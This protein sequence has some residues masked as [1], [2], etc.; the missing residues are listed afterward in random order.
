MTSRK[1]VDVVLALLAHFAVGI[2][3]VAVAASVM[4]SLDVLRRML[5]NSEFA[6]DTDPAAPALGDPD[7]ARRGVDQPP[8]LPVVDASRGQREARVGGAHDRVVRRPPRRAGAYLWTRLLLVGAQVGPEAGQSRPWGP[9]AWAAHHAR[10]ALPAA[11]GL[12]T[13]GYLLL[14]RHSPIVVIVKTLLR[15]IRGRRGAAVAR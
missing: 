7:R 13:A 1:F 15:R 10:L 2:S 4:G 6:W 14:S 9:L 5:M 12:V 11:I 8:L 3:W